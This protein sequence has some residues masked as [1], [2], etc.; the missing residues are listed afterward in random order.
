MTHR[1]EA[2][3]P[4]EGRVRRGPLKELKREDGPAKKLEIVLKCDSF[5]SEEA[6]IAAIERI[7]V[8]E[9]K[10]GVIHSGIGTVSKSDLVMALT[11]SRLVIG[12]DVG[13]MPKLDLWAK[14]HEVEVRL[15]D[16]IYRLTEDLAV[17]ARSL[18][19]PEVEERIA[20][21]ARVI[22]LFKSSPGG[23]I[24]G[25]RV[26][27]GSLVL[28]KNFR[29]ISAA[30]VVYTGRIESLHIEKKAVNEARSSQEA[31]IKVKDFKEVRLG[32]LVEC[33]ERAVQRKP[34]AW[35]PRGSILR[36]KG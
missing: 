35:K 33:F 29:I 9:V 7:H 34:S 2:H 22:A 19:V 36:I 26:E 1:K 30:G 20:G 8:P 11:G 25:C 31:G 12:F 32:D 15:Y 28:G 23:I 17:I 24:L 3:P 16:V 18:V 10:I 5:G 27:E 6:L 14:E 13:V 21:K 4:E